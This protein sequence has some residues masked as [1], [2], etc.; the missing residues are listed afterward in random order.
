MSNRPWVQVPSGVVTSEVGAGMSSGGGA[1][2][3]N[4][5]AHGFEEVRPAARMAAR[6]VPPREVLRKRLFDEMMEDC[7]ED[8]DREKIVHLRTILE[9]SILER[10]VHLLKARLLDEEIRVLSDKLVEIGEKM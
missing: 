4:L 5:E 10:D 8:V 9:K 6:P 7:D 1:E 2:R 3:S